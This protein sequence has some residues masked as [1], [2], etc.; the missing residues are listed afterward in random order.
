MT[1]GEVFMLYILSQHKELSAKDIERI[2]DRD[3]M[4]V[5]KIK[6]IMKSL[7]QKGEVQM[8]YR[9]SDNRRD[10]TRYRKAPE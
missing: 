3:D 6:N 9:I 10:M 4:K 1:P 5:D 7:V 2:V 8:V